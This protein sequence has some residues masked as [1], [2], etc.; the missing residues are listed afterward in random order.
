MDKD[1]II[2]KKVNNRDRVDIIIK[3]II[4]KKS[5]IIKNIFVSY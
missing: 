2:N 3:N 5:K 1:L 4:I